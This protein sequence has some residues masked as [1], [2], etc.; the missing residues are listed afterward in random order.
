MVLKTIQAMISCSNGLIC[1][2]HSCWFSSGKL[3]YMMVGRS[4][5]PGKG[6]EFAGVGGDVVRLTQ[7]CSELDSRSNKANLL[8]PEKRFR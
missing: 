7:T 6:G 8:T 2:D 3:H 1:E 5:F 4:R